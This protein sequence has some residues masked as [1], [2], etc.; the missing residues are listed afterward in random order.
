MA[1]RAKSHSITTWFCRLV[2][3]VI[4]ICV[5][6]FWLIYAIG[7]IGAVI[8]ELFHG[9]CTLSHAVYSHVGFWD[10]ILAVLVLF[11]LYKLK[12]SL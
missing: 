11:V 7:T 9:R 2:V 6:I 5:C 4:I 8:N 12:E 1:S 3:K 10:L